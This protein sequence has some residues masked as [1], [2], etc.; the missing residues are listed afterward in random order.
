MRVS[1]ERLQ[2]LRD[3]YARRTDR[4]DEVDL[5]SELIDARAVARASLRVSRL[6]SNDT[7]ASTGRRIKELADAE[8]TY[9]KRWGAR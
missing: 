3:I 2:E 8:D 9:L 4:A 6:T 5:L 1:D 7:P